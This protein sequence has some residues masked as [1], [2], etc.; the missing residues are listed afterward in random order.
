VWP[1]K[2]LQTDR[3]G[4]T[5]PQPSVPQANS[6]KSG[7]LAGTTSAGGSKRRILKIRAVEKEKTKSQRLQRIERIVDRSGEIEGQLRRGE[8]EKRNLLQ[9]KKPGPNNEAQKCR[10]RVKSANGGE[11][12]GKT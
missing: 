12:K 8:Q 7:S 2:A 5:W 9:E 1:D 6:G 10:R 3:S 11:K 4:E